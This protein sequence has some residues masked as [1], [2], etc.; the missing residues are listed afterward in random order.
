MT[1]IDFTFL[2]GNEGYV[3]CGTGDCKAT[4][5]VADANGKIKIIKCE[6]KNVPG[7]HIGDYIGDEGGSGHVFICLACL[8][9][10]LEA[11]C[12]DYIPGYIT[13]EGT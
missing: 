8:N 10:M 5:E 2:Y 11:D 3:E 6:R 13:S 1:M 7:I 4:E 12:P 9:K